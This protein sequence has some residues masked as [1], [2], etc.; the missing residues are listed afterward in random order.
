[1]AKNPPE[2]RK[3]TA[4]QRAAIQSL[5][6]A[7]AMSKEAVEEAGGTWKTPMRKVSVAE[8]GK[9][10]TT[11]RR[12]D[13]SRILRGKNIIERWYSSERQAA[14]KRQISKKTA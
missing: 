13:V 10:P 7:L 1:M 4:R 12:P 3:R 8:K 2:V 11:T 14:R 9:R 5:A 6:E